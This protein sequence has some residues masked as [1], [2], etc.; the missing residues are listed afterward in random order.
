MFL[1]LPRE[2]GCFEFIRRFAVVLLH[3][4]VSAEVNVLVIVYVYY[5]KIAILCVSI[6]VSMVGDDLSIPQRI[7]VNI[8]LPSHCLVK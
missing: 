4:T 3:P 7:G 2:P 6:V 8:C 1:V 5:L